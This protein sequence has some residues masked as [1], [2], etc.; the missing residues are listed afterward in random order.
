VEILDSDV[1]LE[2]VKELWMFQNLGPN[3]LVMLVLLLSLPMIKSVLT[4]DVKV[5]HMVVAMM[6]VMV[7]VIVLNYQVP[8]LDQVDLLLKQH[9]L[10]TNLVKELPSVV[11]K[12][13]EETNV[14]KLMVMQ[15][16]ELIDLLLKQH[17]M[18]FVL[19]ILTIA[20]TKET[21][22]VDVLSILYHLVNL[23]RD[24]SELKPNVSA[25][26]MI[27][28]VKEVRMLVAI[29]LVMEV[30]LVNYNQVVL[31]DQVDLT[32]KQT[33]LELWLLQELVK[34][35]LFYVIMPVIVVRKLLVIQIVT[36]IDLLLKQDVKL[37]VPGS[38]TIVMEEFVLSIQYLLEDLVVEHS[39]LYKHVWKTVVKVHLSYVAGTVE[40]MMKVVFQ[41]LFLEVLIDN[42]LV[43]LQDM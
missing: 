42:H 21:G 23:V 40:Q 17:A 18:L 43:V 38:L 29:M 33:V 7:V 14:L 2:V 16:V 1:M 26:V 41:L 32:M 22:Q 12:G 39:L 27:I 13:Q 6:P 30:V 20:L 36:E 9:V 8:I 11:N 31:I 37:P 35:H 28:R 5:V 24:L 10:P 4:M 3:Q 25:M 19:E 34:A 15:P